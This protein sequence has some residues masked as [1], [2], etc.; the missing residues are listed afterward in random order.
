MPRLQRH[1]YMS[2]PQI[3][4]FR[5]YK[6]DTNGTLSVVWQQ[7]MEKAYIKTYKQVHND[8]P[9]LFYEIDYTKDFET[10]FRLLPLVEDYHPQY[11]DPE[12]GIGTMNYMIDK[13][14]NSDVMT[15]H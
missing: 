8:C 11:T 1:D 4:P 12:N 9:D 7:Q 6:K 5:Q 2:D 10:Q 15:I 13:T 3:I 14:C